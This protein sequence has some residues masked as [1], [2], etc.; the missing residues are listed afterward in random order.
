MDLVQY[1]RKDI[2][3]HEYDNYWTLDWR[4]D[5]NGEKKILT[6]WYF[7]RKKY[8]YGSLIKQKSHIFTHWDI[9]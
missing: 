8:P 3:D 5:M 4:I 7:N 2:S 6:I 1:T 9:Q